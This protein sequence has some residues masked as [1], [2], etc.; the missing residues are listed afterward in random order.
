MANIKKYCKDTYEELAYHM[1]WPS[2]KE[3]THIAIVT[4]IA[5]IIIAAFV[6]GLDT[7]FKT[8]MGFIYPKA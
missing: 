2:R 8:L 7:L 4:L 1:T 6:L 5:T 3:L